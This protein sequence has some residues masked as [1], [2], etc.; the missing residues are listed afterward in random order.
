MNGKYI[1]FNDAFRLITGYTED[2]LNQLD[3][4]KLT[5]EKYKDL[6]MFQLKSLSET[7]KYGPYEKE[8][9]RKDGTLI[10]IRLRGVLLTGKDG[11][12][13]IWSLVEDITHQKEQ[14][15]R[16]EIMAHYDA[17]TQ[18]PNR[19]LLA[20]RLQDAMLQSI[21]SERLLA[22][23][24]LD[25]D[26][27]KPI[28]DQMGHESGDRFLIEVS[29]KLRQLLR[30]NDTVARLG[31]MNLFYYLQTCNQWKREKIIKTSIK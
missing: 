17:L 6:E 23:C 28:N 16:L 3:Y 2:E 1:E 4:W 15:H 13:F 14:Q 9:L 12:D 19:I 26:E 7:R 21:S 22:I 31:E 11:I 18:L 8:Y 20:E 30:D 25:L 24:Y 27:F 10:P 29:R 5:P